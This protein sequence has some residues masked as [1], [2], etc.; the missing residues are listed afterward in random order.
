[1]GQRRAG[2]SGLGTRQAASRR[3]ERLL[4]RRAS[5]P[6]VPA[7]ALTGRSDDVSAQIDLIG[8]PLLMI[9]EEPSAAPNGGSFAHLPPAPTT[10]CYL[11]LSAT[12]AIG[13]LSVAPRC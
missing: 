8:V 10:L 5:V 13:L 4:V 6:L 12:T 11:R 3:L 9:S 2:C 7:R 1:M